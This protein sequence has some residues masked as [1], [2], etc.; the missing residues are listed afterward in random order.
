MPQYGAGKAEFTIVPDEDNPTEEFP[1]GFIDLTGGSAAEGI[2]VSST[3]D[4]E[5]L[6]EYFESATPA[7]ELT[8]ILPVEVDGDSP[9]SR[10]YYSVVVAPVA[11]IRTAGPED[12]VPAEVLAAC[13]VGE[14]SFLGWVATYDPIDTTFTQTIDGDEWTY[15]ITGAPKPSYFLI[16][17]DETALCLTD[18]TYTLST[19]DSSEITGYFYY[20]F[21]L[22]MP[23]PP[24]DLFP[25][26]TSGELPDFSSLRESFASLTFTADPLSPFQSLGTFSREGIEPTPT[27]TP[28]PQ[29][30][31]AT[32]AD[33]ADL[34]VPAVIAGSVL[35]VGGALVVIAVVRRRRTP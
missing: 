8:P 5:A 30:L 27:P 1:E 24:T 9:S 18:G 15:T 26:S 19:N 6:N 35:L 23:Y 20:L 25:V 22:V 32:G 4:L 10:T 3:N 11:T 29:A 16:T 34:V 14:S 7:E 13:G 31:A 2:D 28:T 12:D 17:E 21:G 33:A